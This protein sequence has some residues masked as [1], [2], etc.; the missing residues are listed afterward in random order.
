M[1][2]CLFEYNF[3]TNSEKITYHGKCIINYKYL[4]I[5]RG[6]VMLL[7]QVPEYTLNVFMNLW[8][9][10]THARGVHYINKTLIFNISTLFETSTSILML[11]MGNIL[12]FYE[13]K[14]CI[15]HAPKCRKTNALFQ[16]KPL[17]GWSKCLLLGHLGLTNFPLG[18]F[19]RVR[20]M[21]FWK[22]W[23]RGLK[24]ENLR[25]RW[26]ESETSD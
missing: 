21:F 15:F 20:I 6:W 24:W 10:I 8:I 17:I 11:V 13:W 22:H 9:L 7:K 3:I 4:T 26:N 23:T 14:F 12:I 16:S 19:R 1:A 25:Q 5:F 2:P 18:L